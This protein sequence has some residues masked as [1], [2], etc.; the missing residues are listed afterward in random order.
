MGGR[1]HGYMRGSRGQGYVGGRGQG[2]TGG[3]SQG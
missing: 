1:G 3:R 2:Y